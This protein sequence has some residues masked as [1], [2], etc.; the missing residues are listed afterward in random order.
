[1]REDWD[2]YFMK[3]AFRV[4]LRS[5]C[6][7]RAVGAVIVRDHRIIST[8][9]NGAPSGLPH[10]TDVGCLL[11]HGHCVRAIHAEA[12]ALLEAPPAGR[13]GATCYVT[14]YPCAKC[15]QLIINSGVR[16]VKYARAYE[17]DVNWFDYASW[18]EVEQMEGA[19][20]WDDQA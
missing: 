12:N 5:T 2:S 7:R 16:T 14:D 11:R 15:A 9:Y 17:V 8:G 1:M 20:R 19:E 10:C 18:I 3:L 13:Q 6:P 4:A